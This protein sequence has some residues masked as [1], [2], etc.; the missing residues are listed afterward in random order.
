M[1][2]KL[3]RAENELASVRQDFARQKEALEATW[4]QRLEDEKVRLQEQQFPPTRIF[5]PRTESPVATLAT[6]HERPGSHRSAGLPISFSEI[7]TPPR[8]NSYSSYSSNPAFRTSSHDLSG[9]SIDIPSGPFDP[10]DYFNG[11][12]TPA[13]PS[14]QGAHSQ[15]ARGINDIISVSTVGAGPSVQLVERMSATV[16]RLENER[17]GLK[18]ELERLTTQRNEARQEVVELMREVEEKRAGDQRIKELEESIEQL[19]QRYQTTLEML[20]EKSEQVE[21]QKAD[22][23]DLKKI[24]R[25]LI[26]SMVK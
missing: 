17:A 22:I 13:T 6:V 7:D 14:A 2:N 26:E 8:Q 18:D 19:D 21:E 12:L 20:G 23:E 1:S 11:A 10:E 16:R 9:P 15:P 3:A 24:Y 4:T 25:E 5:P